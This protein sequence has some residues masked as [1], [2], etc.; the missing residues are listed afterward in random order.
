MKMPTPTIRLSRKEWKLVILI[1]A[2]VSALITMVTVITTS[3]LVCQLLHFL[4]DARKTM[5]IMREAA[6]IYIDERFAEDE[7]AK[8]L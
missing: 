8:Y 5:P 7:Q 4:K 3:R 6:E 1:A 2:V